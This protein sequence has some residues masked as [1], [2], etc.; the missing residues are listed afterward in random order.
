[1]IL[2]IRDLGGMK[3]ADG[4]KLRPGLLVRSA[5]LSAAESGEL[6]GISAVIDLR[7]SRERQELPDRCFGRK[8][9]TL[10]IFDITTPGI[11]H[12]KRAL[13]TNPPDMTRLYVKLVSEI[14]LDYMLK[15]NGLS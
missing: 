12:E 3:T 1:M 8:Y 7:T 10:P 11:T 9:L 13:E 15:A 5:N 6:E 14:N 4:R 2:N